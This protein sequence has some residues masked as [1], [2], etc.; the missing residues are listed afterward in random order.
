MIL[1]DVL[2]S[3]RSAILSCDKELAMSSA[4]QVVEAGID[5][6]ITMEAMTQAMSQVG[7]GFG[8]GDLWLPEL[9]GAAAAMKS[10]MPIIEAEFKR[11]NTERHAL[12][13]VVIGTV[14]GD[15]HD[16]GKR[17][18]E[19]LLVSEN[20]VVHDLGVDLTAEQFLEGV[21]KYQA[22]ILAMSA[23]LTTTTSEMRGVI[24]ALQAEGLRDRVKVMVGGAPV[25]Q[26]FA[27]QI[28]A[29]GYDPTAPGAV[30]LAKRLLKER[31]VGG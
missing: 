30:G 16:L 4:R 23:L 19:T 12:G 26:E 5:P 17:M 24:E 28:G 18:V 14:R 27:E 3:L 20:F 22:D 25:T 31:K 11:S 10:A 6:L 8:R 13:T 7:E 9:V 2:G 1:D 15:I 21:R 29:D